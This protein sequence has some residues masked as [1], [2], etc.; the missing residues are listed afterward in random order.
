MLML[1]LMLPLGLVTSGMA[2][3]AGARARL[4]FIYDNYSRAAAQAKQRRLPIF[5][6]VWAPW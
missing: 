3:M 5:V 4:P 1:P 2:G 6:E